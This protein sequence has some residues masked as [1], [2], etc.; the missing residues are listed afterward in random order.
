MNTS[1]IR[2]MDRKQT[3]YWEIAL[4]LTTIIGVFCAI[5]AGFTDR[6][7]EMFQSVMGTQR[8]CKAKDLEDSSDASSL[9]SSLYSLEDW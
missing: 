3:L 6:I 1:D 8:L 5:I 4:P 7:G 9:Y 2:D